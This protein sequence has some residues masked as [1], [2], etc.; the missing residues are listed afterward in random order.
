[1]LKC[2]GQYLSKWITAGAFFPPGRIRTLALGK[3][4]YIAASWLAVFLY[5][6]T[7]IKLYRPT[8]TFH[9]LRSGFIWTRQT[10]RRLTH[11]SSG[12]QCRRT[13]TLPEPS[14]LLANTCTKAKTQSQSSQNVTLKTW[15]GHASSENPEANSFLSG[16]RGFSLFVLQSWPITKLQQS[17]A[18]SSTRH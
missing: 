12:V 6:D 13:L 11:M 2:Y 7:P 9:S 15:G 10:R 16:H 18:S 4:L 1:M 14:F 5:V 17:H 8:E 3:N